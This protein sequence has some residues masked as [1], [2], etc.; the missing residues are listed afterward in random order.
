MATNIIIPKLGTLK[1]DATLVEWKAGEGDKVDRDS[2]VL[3]VETKKIK[4]DIQAEAAGYLHIMV[5]EGVEAPVGTVVGAIAASM[6]ELEALKKQSPPPVVKPAVKSEAPAAPPAASA[7]A[8]ASEKREGIRISPVARKMAEENMID[9]TTV[10]GTG[11]GG[12]IVREDIEKAIA[13]R[14]AAPAPEVFYGKTGQ[15]YYPSQRHE[16]GHRRAH[17]PQPGRRR[18]AYRHG[19]D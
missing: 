10:T 17:A 15:V 1:V 19:R 12:R 8:I 3:E 14:A 9:I 13:A 4:Y 6:E 18:P 2:V 16:G 5:A 7:P 11:P